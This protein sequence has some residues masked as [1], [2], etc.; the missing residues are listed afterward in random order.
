MKLLIKSYRH[1]LWSD[2]YETFGEDLTEYYKISQT[3]WNRFEFYIHHYFDTLD[4]HEN[5]KVIEFLSFKGFQV[6]LTKGKSRGDIFQFTE[7]SMFV[8]KLMGFESNG[9]VILE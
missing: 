5:K 7:E 1:I 8:L 6:V 4:D 9:Y 2:L 3:H